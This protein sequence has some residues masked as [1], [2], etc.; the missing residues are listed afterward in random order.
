MSEKIT[1]LLTSLLDRPIAFHR[2][3]V[4]LTGSVLGALFLSQ[5]VYWQHRCPRAD[6]WWYKSAAEWQ[7]ETGMRRYELEAARKA[8]GKFVQVKK[9][10]VPCTT[11]YKIDISGLQSS[12]SAFDKLD[13]RPSANKSVGL[14]QTITETT[15]ETTSETTLNLPADAAE[16]EKPVNDQSGKE[17]SKEPTEHKKFTDGW[18][19]LHIEIFGEK[20][21]YAG[22]DF[23]PLKELLASSGLTAAD[24]L[25]VVRKAWLLDPVKN[26]FVREKANTISGF[27]QYFPDIKA[28]IRGP[29]RKPIDYSNF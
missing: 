4:D 15:S 8:C 22:R 10:G 27:C 18:H 12:L 5:S 28:A 19:D 11:F 14:R 16:I 20:Y 7:E 24:L 25:A 1:N 26:K 3:F 21:F 17:Q 23:R 29:V 13:C 6:G 9:E 2:C